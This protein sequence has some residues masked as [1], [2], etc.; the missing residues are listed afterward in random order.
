[1]G[2]TNK[3]LQSELSLDKLVADMRTKFDQ[4]ADGRGS[5]SQYALS[6]VLICPY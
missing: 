5:N 2:K 6:D 3:Q 4:I 1:M